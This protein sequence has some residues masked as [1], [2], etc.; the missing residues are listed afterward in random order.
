[1]FKPNFFLRIQINMLH[2]V[3]PQQLTL[4]IFFLRRNQTVSPGRGVALVSC[5]LATADTESTMQLPALAGAVF[6]LQFCLA[7]LAWISRSL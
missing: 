2:N 5:R 1:L 3:S 7:S 6:R 4:F